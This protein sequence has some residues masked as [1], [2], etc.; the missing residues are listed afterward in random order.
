[1]RK[2]IVLLSLSI[3]SFSLL[4]QTGKRAYANEDLIVKFNVNHSSN[5][6]L[7]TTILE[8]S[9]NNAICNNTNGE[10]FIPRN[11]FY[12]DN[13]FKLARL[14]VKL[15]L[16]NLSGELH[17]TGGCTL[18]NVYLYDYPH[19]VQDLRIKEVNNILM[20]IVAQLEDSIK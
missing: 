13:G 7:K 14:K 3:I 12:T 10:V 11:N 18:T 20:M 4:G 2:L 8:C 6:I 1:M 17:A 15:E 5:Y 16:F 19:I 9:A